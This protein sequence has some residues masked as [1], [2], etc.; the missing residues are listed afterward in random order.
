LPPSTGRIRFLSV[1]YS[2]YIGVSATQVT[3]F[4]YS[5]EHHQM[6]RQRRYSVRTVNT[7]SQAPFNV[8]QMDLT[9]IPKRGV[10]RYLLVVVDTF[11]KYG[12]VQ[13]LA[14][15]DAPTVARELTKILNSMPSGAKIGAIRSDN[16]GEFKAQV[17]NLLKERGIK[18]IFGLPHSPF[19]QGTVG[20]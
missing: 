10:H 8:L 2:K 18:Q 17:S 16:G 7:V 4:L 5:N 15:K 14:K 13:P 1:L 20:K 3:A 6:W 12:W 19:G 11:S 9:D